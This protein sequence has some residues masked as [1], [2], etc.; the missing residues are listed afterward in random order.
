VYPLD[1]VLGILHPAGSLARHA[2]KI[3]QND[4]LFDSTRGFGEDLPVNPVDETTL[5]AL[6]S[7]SPEND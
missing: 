1:V 5:V 2:R 7:T 3:G 4:F 6:T